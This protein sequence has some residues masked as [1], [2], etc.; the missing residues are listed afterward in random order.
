MRLECRQRPLL[1]PLLEQRAAAA[2]SQR[3]L[4]EEVGARYEAFVVNTKAMRGHEA[5]SGGGGARGT[6]ASAKASPMSLCQT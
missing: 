6:R 5:E 2:A 4:T 1:P 3:M